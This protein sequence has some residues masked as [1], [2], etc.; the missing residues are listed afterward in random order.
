M[1]RKILCFLL[2]LCVI[3]ATLALALQNPELPRV[4][5]HANLLSEEEERALSETIT[6][7]ID[8]YGMDVVILTVDS[9][10]GKSAQD[11]ADDYFDY[12][13]Y[14]C[15][16]D[17]SGI[18]FLLSMEYRDWW[19]STCGD[20]IY[21][22]TDY[23]IEQL[24]SEAAYYLADDRYYLGFNAWLEAIPAFLDAFR[25]GNHID[26][27]SGSDDGPGSYTPDERDDV[28]Y[29][30]DDRSIL[31]QFL[32]SLVIGL[33]AATITVAIMAGQMNTKRAQS[34]AGAYVV[35]GSFNLSIHRDL[36]LYS[37]VHKTAKPKESS[38][39]G[40]GGSSVHRSSSGRS[41]G[42]GGGKF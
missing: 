22:F 15:G 19:M 26:G 6:S 10:S 40:G 38:S 30:E 16:E 23:G 24:F 8:E 41:H 42:G 21:A 14:G 9:L 34:S 2:C 39:G 27:Y 29:Y 20:G 1:K 37:S 28:V 5:D 3:P 18:L 33:V 35:P 12:E 31:G 7:I 13:G 17:W 25:D 4:V 36:F 32:L 11:Y